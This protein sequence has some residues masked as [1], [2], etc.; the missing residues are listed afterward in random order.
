M[1][2]GGNWAVL[3]VRNQAGQQNIGDFLFKEYKPTDSVFNEEG[4][5]CIAPFLLL[6]GL[7]VLQNFMI[8]KREVHS[9]AF[10]LSPSL[11]LADSEGDTIVISKEP[12]GMESSI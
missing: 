9:S 4:W 1:P 2:V 3:V 12:T 5:V 10:T 8:L 6:K 7:T 11:R